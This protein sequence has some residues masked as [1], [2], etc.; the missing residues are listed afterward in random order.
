MTVEIPAYKLVYMPVPKAACTSV[1]AALSTI[2]P[3]KPLAPAQIEEDEHI[4]HD[5][6]Q[7]RRFRPHRWEPFCDGTWWR[8]AVI[9][10]PLKRVLS[11]YT[12]MIM[13]RNILPNSPRL[14]DQTAL[15]IDPDPDFFFQNLLDYMEHSSIIKHHALS[16]HLFIG[17]DPSQFDRWYRTDELSLLAQ[18]MSEHVGEEVTIPRFNSSKGKLDPDALTLKTH[19]HLAAFLDEE[20]EVLE[21][22]FPNP[23]KRSI[24]A[25]I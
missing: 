17:K 20:Y 18:D 24:H 4:V 8:F 15:P 2:D 9:R 22:Y 11:V 3:A 6:Y 14:R 23:Y 21:N 1:K 7:T 5:A 12:D 25:Q 16:S 10:D 19:R 13:S